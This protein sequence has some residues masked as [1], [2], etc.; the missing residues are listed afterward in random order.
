MHTPQLLMHQLPRDRVALTVITRTAAALTSAALTTEQV[1]TLAERLAQPRN[2]WCEDAWLIRRSSD[3]RRVTLTF[4]RQ[5]WGVDRTAVVELS[6]DDARSLAADLVRG[7]SQDTPAVGPPLFAQP[8]ASLRR[9][10]SLHR[11]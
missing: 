9:F 6:D 3:G 2:H 4:Y 5:V 7:L 1:R 8:W 10:M 11:I